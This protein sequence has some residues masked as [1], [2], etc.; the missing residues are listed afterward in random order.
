MQNKIESFK[1]LNLDCNY[2]YM[3]F[4]G[5]AQGPNKDRPNYCPKCKSIYVKWVNW[6][7]DW[8]YDIER[9]EW[10]RKMHVETIV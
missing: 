8:W 6:E 4:S 7:K 1:C 2:E 3:G 5:P 9:N 10:K